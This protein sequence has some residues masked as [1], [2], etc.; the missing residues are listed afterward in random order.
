M[1]GVSSCSPGKRKPIE[2][3]SPIPILPSPIHLSKQLSFVKLVQ[4]IHL[5]SRNLEV[6]FSASNL[7]DLQLFQLGSATRLPLPDCRRPDR[8]SFA[9]VLIIV[10]AHL[11]IADWTSQILRRRDYS[12]PSQCSDSPSSFSNRS[13]F[14]DSALL[15]P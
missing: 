9:A 8:R 2:P 14:P 10:I 5:L 7:Q 3:T 4:S 13:N 15:E 6:T 11:G 1:I 12:A